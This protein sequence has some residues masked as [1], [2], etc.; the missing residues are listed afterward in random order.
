M[1]MRRNITDLQLG[2]D[3]V[4]L[5]GGNPRDGP[6]AL[7]TQEALRIAVRNNGDLSFNDSRPAS[8]CGGCTY[9]EQNNP[10]CD[11]TGR[12]RDWCYEKNIPC[13]RF[14]WAGHH[15]MKTKGFYPVK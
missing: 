11:V 9:D 15:R 1:I 2:S 4:P 5:P 8:Y 12:D 7:L 13:N 14:V 10:S 6:F 3:Y